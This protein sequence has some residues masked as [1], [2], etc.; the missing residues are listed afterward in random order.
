MPGMSET[1]PAGRSWLKPALAAGVALLVVLGA[2]YLNAPEATHVKVG[3]PAPDMELMSEHGGTQR[4]SI[5]RGGA[6][7]LVFFMSDCHIC[8]E[9]IP[10]LELVNR[11]FRNKGLTVLGVSVD[12]DYTTYKNFILKN[13]LTFGMYRDPGGPRI[14]EAFGSYKLPEAYLIDATGTVA[15]V[16]LGKVEWRGRKVREQIEDVL[17][18]TP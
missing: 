7:L 4:L 15:A 3:M 13:Q 6:V 8:Q 1:L 14:L 16:W 9:D 11:E 12:N 2:W 10:Q 5:Y 17:P 18:K